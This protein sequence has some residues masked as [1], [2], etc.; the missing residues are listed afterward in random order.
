MIHWWDLQQPLSAGDPRPEQSTE[1]EQ[2][3]R[4][5]PYLDACLI[6][7]PAPMGFVSPAAVYPESE[8]TGEITGNDPEKLYIERS[9]K[10]R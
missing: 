9:K 8:S 3:K 1:K 2:I 10:N 6:F 5:A 7:M 4:H